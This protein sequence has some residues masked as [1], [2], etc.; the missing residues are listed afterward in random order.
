MDDL[1]DLRADPLAWI[2]SNIYDYLAGIEWVL[3]D[4]DADDILDPALEAYIIP[5]FA[6]AGIT[7]PERAE[8]IDGINQLVKRMT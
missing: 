2:M 6:K 3:D 4:M 8:L 5:Q 1:D 7:V